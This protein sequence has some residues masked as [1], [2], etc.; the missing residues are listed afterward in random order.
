[1]GEARLYEYGLRGPG[2]HAAVG[3]LF[4]DSPILLYRKPCEHTHTLTIADLIQYG[5]DSVFHFSPLLVFR[6]SNLVEHI[7]V[8]VSSYDGNIKNEVN[9]R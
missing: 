6:C 1:V 7:P 8:L 2:T 4:M 3:V 9:F 5:Y